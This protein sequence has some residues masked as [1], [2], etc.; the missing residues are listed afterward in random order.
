MRIIDR[1]Q[2]PSSIRYFYLTQSLLNKITL[3]LGFQLKNEHYLKTAEMVK[4]SPSL[5]PPGHNNVNLQWYIV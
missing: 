3:M 2:N 1:P 4:I 5:I